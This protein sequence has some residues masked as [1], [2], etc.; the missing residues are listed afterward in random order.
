MGLSGII[1]G[2]IPG[3]IMANNTGARLSQTQHPGT[4]QNVPGAASQ[5]SQQVLRLL[6]FLFFRQGNEYKKIL[7]TGW[8][9]ASQ[10]KAYMELSHSNPTGGARCFS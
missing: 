10:E 7:L 5:S 1:P 9:L 2:I 6:L 4:L 3:I 8:K